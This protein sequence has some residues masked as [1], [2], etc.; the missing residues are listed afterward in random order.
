[1]HW[2][3]WMKYILNDA[4]GVEGFEGFGSRSDLLEPICEEK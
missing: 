4:T 3:R 1:M 2:R